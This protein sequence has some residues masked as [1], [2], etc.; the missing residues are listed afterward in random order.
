MNRV[1]F[2]RRTQ[3]ITCLVEGNSIQSTERMTTTHR[4]RHGLC[5]CLVSVYYGR[6]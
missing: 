3:I 5:Y 4:D 1:P 2:E 6:L